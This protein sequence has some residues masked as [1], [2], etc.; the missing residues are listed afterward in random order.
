M[1]DV[2]SRAHLI[3]L[4]KLQR[5]ILAS[6]EEA[7]EDHLS[8]LTNTVISGRG[9]QAEVIAMRDALEELQRAGFINFARSTDKTTLELIPMDTHSALALLQQLE[10]YLAGLDSKNIWALVPEHS[11]IDILLTESGKEAARKVLS[12]DGFVRSKIT[13]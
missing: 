11:N 7:G 9:R 2:P 5:L 8:A 13:I 4:T 6:L 1:V 3:Q 10:S 12:E